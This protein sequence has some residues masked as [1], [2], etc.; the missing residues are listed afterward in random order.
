ML[1]SLQW[2]YVSTGVNDSKK[3]TTEAQREQVYEL[4]TKNPSVQWNVGIVDAPKIDEINIL[5]VS[6]EQ[7]Y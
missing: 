1:L 7:G 6:R 4:L 5:Q 3:I 2:N